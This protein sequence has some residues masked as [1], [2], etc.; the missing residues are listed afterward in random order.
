MM[1]DPLI[2]RVISNY[3]IDSFLGGG[4]M[5]KVYK[6]SDLNMGERAVA[7]KVLHDHLARDENI[8]QRFKNEAIIL[9][10]LNHPNIVTVYLFDVEHLMIVME[11][12]DGPPLDVMIEEMT[13]ALVFDRLI[14]LF[15]PILSSMDYAHRQGVIH[16]D[17]KPSNIMIASIDGQQIPKVMDFGIAKILDHEA[18]MTATGSS[19]G[20]LAY[21]APEQIKNAA[22]IDHRADIYALGI[23]LY[24]MATGQIPF[25]HD[26]EFAIMKAHIDEE[27]PP[28]SQL[29]PG[30][31][32][33][34]EGIILKAMAKAPADRY[35]SVA[36]LRGALLALA[37]E[38]GVPLGNT[39]GLAL[40]KMNPGAPRSGSTET[41]VE[42][43]QPGS[44]P[45]PFSDHL[46]D[47]VV[48]LK[49]GIS[50][51]LL[52]GL[53]AG[54][55]ILILCLVVFLVM[56]NKGGSRVGSASVAVATAEEG[57]SA[58]TKDEPAP[59]GV[60]NTQALPKTPEPPFESSRDDPKAA[61]A[62]GESSSGE[63]PMTYRARLSFRDHRN[64]RGKPLKS[65]A[66][67]IRQDRANFHRYGVRD[68]GDQS[69]YL[70]GDKS[71]RAR[72]LQ[73]LK[74]HIPADVTRQIMQ[75]TPLIEVQ[76]WSDRARVVLVSQ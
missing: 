46:D 74:G 1:D 75:G 66:S 38:A 51:P 57:S 27:P 55:A 37:E 29:Y 18:K 43:P 24:E 76:V 11:Y 41:I 32:P 65:A 23:T 73:I 69:D 60:G 10:K 4:G 9:G 47:G 70:F 14:A 72:I 49:K 15:D 53:I 17:M 52:V 68:D 7:I 63:Q 22:G 5:G 3:R 50:T 56:Q 20:T 12:V 48:P 28:P 58:M 2:N 6:G 25:Q 59:T 19:M 54:A 64:S 30:I 61:P 34:L 35:Q 16:R 42:S 44:D 45:T 36:D 67:I 33:D 8:R 26:S 71:Q 62:T 21:S 13:G 40:P 31:S 39:S